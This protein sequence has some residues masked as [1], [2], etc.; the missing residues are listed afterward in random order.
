[1]VVRVC[2]L[3]IGTMMSSHQF[4]LQL[5]SPTLLKKKWDRHSQSVFPRLKHFDLGSKVT[6]L[7]LAST[8]S[9]YRVL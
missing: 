4:T 3:E 2:I 9:T 7:L 8:P 5:H 6:M 1:M